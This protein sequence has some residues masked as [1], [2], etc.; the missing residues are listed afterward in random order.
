VNSPASS[1]RLFQA[2]TFA[3]LT[4]GGLLILGLLQGMLLARGLGPAGLGRYSAA[5][6]DVNL[7]VALL[8]LGLPGALAVLQS[9][10]APQAATARLRALRRLAWRRGLVIVLVLGA[11][12]L[13]VRL[14]A[15]RFERT[16]L[17]LS[18]IAAGVLVQYARDVENGLLWGG[19]RFSTQNRVN[20][21]VQALL[22]AGLC[23][24]VFF[25]RISPEAALALQL[26]GNLAWT[27]TAVLLRP[28]LPT[29][30]P[31]AV[32]DDRG[33]ARRVFSVGLRNYLSLLIDLLVLRIDVYL[34]QTLLPTAQRESAL[35]LYQAGVRV[36]ELVL[37]L[38][39]T[40]NALLFA[41]AAAK[42]DV[43]AAALHS[44]KL[45]LWVGLLA[46]AGMWLVG[47]PLLVL[48]FGARFGG[49]FGPC[50]WVLCGCVAMC[51]SG[52][53]AGT[54]QGDAGYPRSVVLAQGAALFV[55]VAANLYLLPRHGI[56]GAAAA[57]ALSYTVSAI[58]ICVA[59]ARRFAISASAILRPEMP[60]T[61]YA[62]LRGV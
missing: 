31:L 3:L 23:A 8:S 20:L 5:L 46:L 60:W 48:F 51:F 50:L 10:A 22:C 37:M 32:G 6:V 40:L 26:F 49:A 47:Q 2:A 4:R 7:I 11:A 17:I 35:E 41:K 52:P 14:F 44:A 18:L 39:G 9:E 25:E 43:A 36:A 62:R 33:L 30:Q 16:P 38:P 13:A 19:Q 15:P 56:A 45:S 24:L 58:I 28:P 53:L 21:L 12:A 57:S 42:E 34:I 59:F 29:G 27:L 55:N 54:L 1:P 61:L